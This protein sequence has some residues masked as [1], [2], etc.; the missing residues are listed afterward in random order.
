MTL[1]S[2]NARIA[3][4]DALFF[5]VLTEPRSHRATEPQRGTHHAPRTI[6]V[7]PSFSRASLK[8]E[9]GLPFHSGWAEVG[10]DLLLVSRIDFFNGLPFPNSPSSRRSCRPEIVHRT[11]SP[12]MR[13]KW[14]PDTLPILLTFVAWRPSSP[15]IASSA[16]PSP[17]PAAH[18]RPSQRSTSPFRFPASSLILWLRE[19]ICRGVNWTC[20]ML[21]RRKYNV[22]TGREARTTL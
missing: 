16:V 15:R 10:E 12:A 3:N 20:F 8:L 1:P 5:L 11:L 7:M 6:R 13:S 14:E 21:S 4:S 22:S 19:I 18:G 9:Q 2:W 17:G